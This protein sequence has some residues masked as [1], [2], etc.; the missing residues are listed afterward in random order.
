MAKPKS[1]V[2]TVRVV[3]PLESYASQLELLLA[4]RG[5]A[6]L[7]RV[8]H[9]QVLTHLSKWLRRGGLGCGI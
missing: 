8:T 7:T 2:I 9:L 6:P 4:E 5:Y 1:K 3:G